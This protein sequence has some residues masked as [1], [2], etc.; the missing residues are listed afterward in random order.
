MQLHL[1]SGSDRSPRP[2][3]TVVGRL[4][5]ALSL[6]LLATSVAS[7]VM[8][9]MGA[10]GACATHQGAWELVAPLGVI[11]YGFLAAVGWLGRLLLF[12]I[13]GA[14][15]A[16]VHT[17]LLAAMLVE[18]RLCP[19]CVIACALAAGLFLVILAGASSRARLVAGAYLPALIIA[20]GPVAWALAHE[21]AAEVERQAF[22]HAIRQA[23]PREALAI[24]VFEQ[25]QCGYCRD[26]REFYVPR[27]ERD[28]ALQVRVRFLPATAS[29]WV[30]RTPTIVVEGG[31]IYEGL[32]ASYH[33][34]RSAVEKALGARK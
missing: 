13:G 24:Q 18:G 33:E 34:L 3:P 9:R 1:T 31:P 26:F 4:A 10:C 29:T 2:A 21:R 15:A 20:S 5:L 7:A 12:S 17:V 32:P 28:F 19:L 11:G 23:D 16:G 6:A 30:R 14:V 27:L 22:A 8:P 25:D